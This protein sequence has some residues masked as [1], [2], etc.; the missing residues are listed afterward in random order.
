MI[1]PSL[2][3]EQK[4]ALFQANNSNFSLESPVSRKITDGMTEGRISCGI[5]LIGFEIL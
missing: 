2:M 5:V 4:K 3:E 1:E